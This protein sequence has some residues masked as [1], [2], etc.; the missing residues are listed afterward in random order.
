[1]FAP[2]PL[3]SLTEWPLLNVAPDVFD[4]PPGSGANSATARAA[5]IVDDLAEAG[6]MWGDELAIDIDGTAPAKAP[7]A[8]ATGDAAA[9]G[10]WGD[11]LD[12]EI[13]EEALAA[14]K[15]AGPVFVAPRSIPGRE[16]K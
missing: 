14:S 5:A 10:G 2:I 4:V 8:D 11:E 7:A 6:N 1:M 9:A 15:A 13:P 16:Q 12:I 3:N